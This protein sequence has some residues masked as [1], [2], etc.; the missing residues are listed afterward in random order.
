VP[1]VSIALTSGT[2]P[3]CAGSS[4]TFTATPTNGGATPA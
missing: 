3:M 4:A 2:N 1:S